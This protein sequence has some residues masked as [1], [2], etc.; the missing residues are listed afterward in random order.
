MSSGCFP[1][2][3]SGVWKRANSRR[4]TVIKLEHDLF[5]KPVPTT[6]IRSGGRLFRAHALGYFLPSVPN[7]TI[8]RRHAREHRHFVVG[9]FQRVDEFLTPDFDFVFGDNALTALL[10]LT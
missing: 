7:G 1:R 2:F 4:L 3:A 6:R 5:R 8:G 10:P 9:Q